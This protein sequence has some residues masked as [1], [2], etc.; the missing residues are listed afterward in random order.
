MNTGG[1]PSFF[2]NKRQ[3]KL[4]TKALKEAQDKLKRI[5]AED[6]GD[7]FGFFGAKPAMKMTEQ[8]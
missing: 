5:F 7:D 2:I 1:E 4:D 6:D 3:M 8:S